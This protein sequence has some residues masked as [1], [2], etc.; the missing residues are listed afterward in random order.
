M[1]LKPDKDGNIILPCAGSRKEG[2]SFQ[3]VNDT[4]KTI[5]VTTDG[6]ETII[7]EDWPWWIKG[8]KTMKDNKEIVRG[9]LGYATGHLI[10]QEHEDVM[11]EQALTAL[12]KLTNT[13]AFIRKLEGIE[14]LDH[15]CS[16][17]G[18]VEGFGMAIS[19]IIKEL[20]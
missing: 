2:D 18:Q 12:D 8:S 9:A 3:I 16:T 10:L 15:G 19:A 11:F 7:L 1:K 5:T 20:S 6:T 17:D 13:E 14:C 4:D